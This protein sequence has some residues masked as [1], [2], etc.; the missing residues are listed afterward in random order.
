MKPKKLGMTNPTTQ[1]PCLSSNASKRSV[2]KM[3]N[4]LWQKES[5]NYNA[6]THK[7]CF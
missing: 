4:F 2:S 1:S 7:A 6:T 5:N 3:A